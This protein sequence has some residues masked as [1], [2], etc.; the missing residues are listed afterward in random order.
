[1]LAD[2]DDFKLIND[3]FGHH[4]GDEVLQ[5]FADVIRAH[6]RDVDVGAR[7]GGEEFAVLLPETGLA[8]ATAGAERLCRAFSQ[9]QIWL[10]E[11]ERK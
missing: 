6:G 4:A 3:R 2:L 9:A 8:G 7:L 11:G 1:M 10:G 5:V